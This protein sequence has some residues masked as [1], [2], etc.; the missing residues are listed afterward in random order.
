MCEYINSIEG[1]IIVT[2]KEKKERKE[3]WQTED[4]THTN[5]EIVKYFVFFIGLFF[6]HQKT[7]S[8]VTLKLAVFL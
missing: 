6:Y 7:F 3:P 2:G 5:R 1:I 4:K 8:S